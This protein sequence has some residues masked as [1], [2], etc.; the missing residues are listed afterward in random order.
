MITTTK[1]P[2]QIYWPKPPEFYFGPSAKK[3]SATIRRIKTPN[4]EVYFPALDF[5]ISPEK[6][7]INLDEIV[8]R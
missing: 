4:P 1:L 3:S 7:E 6:K 2:G 5:R 8:A